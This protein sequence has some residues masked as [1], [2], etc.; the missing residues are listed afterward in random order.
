MTTIRDEIEAW[1]NTRIRGATE[2]TR[3]TEAYN[4]MMRAV[5]EL[6]TKP[7]VNLVIQKDMQIKS[8][9]EALGTGDQSST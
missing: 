7:W 2:M 3:N 5:D 1:R 9:A 6:L 4:H 8:P